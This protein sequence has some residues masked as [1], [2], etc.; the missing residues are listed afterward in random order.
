MGKITFKKEL[1]ALLNR[2]NK[3]NNSNT[4]DFIL[5]N[6]I[7]DCLLAFD[8]AVL[9]RSKWFGFKELEDKKLDEVGF[10]NG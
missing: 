3:E 7:Q 1:I 6:Y 4:P 2:Y 5:A 8:T 10:K 9:R